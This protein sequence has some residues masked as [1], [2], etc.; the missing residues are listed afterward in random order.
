[1]KKTAKVTLHLVPPAPYSNS[2]V[3]IEGKLL[4]CLSLDVNFDAHAIGTL[5]IKLGLHRVD[6]SLEPLPTETEQ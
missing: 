3:E 5:T 4:P 6:L 2:W 1:M